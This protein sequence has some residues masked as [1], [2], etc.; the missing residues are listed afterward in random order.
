MQ[1]IIPY[2]QIVLAV[3]LTTLILLQQSDATAGGAFGQSDNWGAGFHTRRGSE[4]TIFV[5]TIVI[6]ILFVASAIVTLLI[7]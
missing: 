1:T 7:K 6:A 3:L 2:V 5:S 4:Q